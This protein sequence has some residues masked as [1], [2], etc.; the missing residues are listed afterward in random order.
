M[1]QYRWLRWDLLMDNYALRVATYSGQTDVRLTLP[2][3]VKDSKL[4]LQWAMLRSSSCFIM[5]PQIAS[6]LSDDLQTACFPSQRLDNFDT[7]RCICSGPVKAHQF[8]SLLRP[9][10]VIDLDV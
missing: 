4:P 2:R 1:G 9:E 5:L 3:T 7:T 10:K 8:R 6:L